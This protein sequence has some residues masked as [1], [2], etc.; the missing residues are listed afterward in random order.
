MT[1]RVQSRD[2]DVGLELK[3][4]RQSHPGI[5]AVASFVGLVRDMHDGNTL[6]ALTLEHYPGMTEKSLEAIVIKAKAR[7]EIVEALI[8]HRV[9]SLQV[10][11][12]IV[13]V[14]TASAHRA[15]ALSACA[16]IMDFLKTEAPFWK[17]ET[18]LSSEHWVEAKH[19]DDVAKG[20]WN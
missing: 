1:V 16:F 12:Q 13:L 20:R 14:A 18:T 7:W 15:E 8:I 11:D 3:Q 9:G 2:F 10:N 19:S 4:L 17:K 6:T 5:G